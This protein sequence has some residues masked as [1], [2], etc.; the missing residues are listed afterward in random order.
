M[1]VA[2]IFFVSVVYFLIQPW[3]CMMIFHEHGLGDNK[4][5]NPVCSI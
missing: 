2:P 3:L 4:T 1:V 5:L